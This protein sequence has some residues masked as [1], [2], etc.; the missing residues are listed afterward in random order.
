MLFKISK[1]VTPVVKILEREKNN[2]IDLI[3]MFIRHSSTNSVTDIKETR[4][5][6]KRSTHVSIINV[7]CHIVIFVLN[8]TQ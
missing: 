6:M 2:P 7:D 3:W 4:C 5:G 8:A 1:K